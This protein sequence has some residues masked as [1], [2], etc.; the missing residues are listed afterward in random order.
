MVGPIY[1]KVGDNFNVYASCSLD[2]LKLYLFQDGNPFVQTIGEI[3][4]LVKY[5]TPPVTQLTM[6]SR[7][8]SS[9]RQTSHL[10][11]SIPHFEEIYR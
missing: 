10:H 11:P 1:S 4:L 5:P 8:G 9:A 3:D 7:S 2:I 6:R